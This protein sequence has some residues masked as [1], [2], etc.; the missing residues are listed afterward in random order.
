[1]PKV[2][3]AQHHAEAHMVC[4]CLRANG[5][6]AEVRGE[7]LFTTMEAP[8]IIPGVA[9]EVWVLDA[10]HVPPALEWCRRYATGEATPGSPWTCPTCG[11]EHEPQ[12]TTCWQCNTS[13]PA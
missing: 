8:S 1:M 12:F 5:I 10:R 4:G 11:E 2:F 6:D 3:T 7:A 9:P 13:N